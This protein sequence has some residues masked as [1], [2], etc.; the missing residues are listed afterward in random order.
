MDG[1]AIR[2]QLCTLGK[3][4]QPCVPACLSPRRAPLP[5]QEHSYWDAPFPQRIT[6]EWFQVSKKKAQK[7]KRSHS[8][9]QGLICWE[10]RRLNEGAMKSPLVGL[11]EI[12]Q[13]EMSHGDGPQNGTQKKKPTQWH[14]MKAWK[15]RKTVRKLK[16]K[17]KKTPITDQQETSKNEK[18]TQNMQMRKTWQE[19]PRDAKQQQQ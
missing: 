7:Q 6:H 15:G 12:Q 10:N 11:S 1:A 18:E 9:F 13:S 4:N 16:H 17:S 14:N 19:E 3:L 8:K 5:L 2:V